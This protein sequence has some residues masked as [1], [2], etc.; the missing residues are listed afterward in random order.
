MPTERVKGSPNVDEI[1]RLTALGL[2]VMT[3]MAVADGKMDEASEVARA[4]EGRKVD[5]WCRGRKNIPTAL[6]A[7][8]DCD[9]ALSQQSLMD[10][11]LTARFEG[12]RHATRVEMIE[13]LE[14]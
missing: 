14:R 11:F 10:A 3:A 12:G 8:W 2:N 1:N 4:E 6:T 13:A 5:L 7:V 9:P